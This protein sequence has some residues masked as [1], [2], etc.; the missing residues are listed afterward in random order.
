MERPQI[1]ETR[2]KF[3]VFIAFTANLYL[4]GFAADAGLSLAEEILRAATGADTL[5]NI[6][7]NVAWSVFAYSILM[8]PIL[9]FTPQLPKLVIFPLIVF[10]LWAGLGAPPFTPTP[11]DSYEQILLILLQVL[12]ALGAFLILKV[13]T[14]AF[15]LSAS[16]LPKKQHLIRRTIIA[17]FA[18]VILTP[19]VISVLGVA[20]LVS[21]V[22]TGTGNYVRFTSS[23]IN[24]TERV[25]S[26]RKKEIRLIGMVH[27]GEGD[28]YEALFNGFP[29]NALVLAEGVTDKEGLMSGN[30]SY[31]RVAKI[32]GLQQQP[33]LQQ[34]E[35]VKNDDAPSGDLEYLPPPNESEIQ[36]VDRPHILTADRDM[37]DFSKITIQ[38]LG[39]TAK[40]YSSTSLSQAIERFTELNENFSE[41]DVNAVFDDILYKRN[42][43]VLAALD[44]NSD[45]YDAIIIPWGA[46]HM[47]GLEE[48]LAE[49]GY[50][51]KSEKTLPL[52]RYATLLA[53]AKKA[54]AS[55]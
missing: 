29:S 5:T 14:G 33:A 25:F 8:L 4:I 20:G 46:M 11:D 26:N 23:G 15:F 37:S 35:R 43:G 38:F 13:R 17:A 42:D 49:R 48:G 10:A 1:I 36:I 24:I 7:N 39:A 51:L 19:V 44:A 41:E 45:A 32:L 6:R 2:S 53:Q 47:P 31:D 16:L 9:L 27:M 3:L 52:I 34:K 55:R 50:R 21:A 40:L 54:L 18:F 30:L 12:F 28:A 22:E